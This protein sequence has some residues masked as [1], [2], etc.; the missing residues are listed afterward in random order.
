[1][2]NKDADTQL[3]QYLASTPDQIAELL[4]K[5]VFRVVTLEEILSNIPVFN[6]RFIDKIKDPWNDKAYEKS[7]LAK[8][9]Y[10]NKNKNLVLIQSLTI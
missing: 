8:K 3:S 4:E 7:C 10:N 1:M 6:L 5:D 9:A 2:T